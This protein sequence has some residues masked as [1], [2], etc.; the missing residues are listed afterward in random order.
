MA[1]LKGEVEKII[2]SGCILAVQP[3]ISLMRSFDQRAH[4]YKG[5][6]LRIEGVCGDNT[7]EFL[8][9]VGKEAH[10]K[11]Q[12][13]RGMMLSGESCPVLNPRLETAEF[14]KTSRIK[15]INKAGNVISQPPPFHGISPSLE[16]YR[17][18]G[19][20]RLD[21]RTFESKCAT[22][23]WG[24]RMPVE[25]TID[26]WN[27]SKKRYRLETFCYGPKIC[28]SYKAGA[29]RRVPGRNGITWEEEDWVDQEMTLH[30]EPDD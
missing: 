15:V 1:K 18:R 25:I 28:P 12:F 2:W 8:I 29:T 3:R 17:Q 23:I 19:H 4:S 7:G 27:P 24:C 30:R 16:I 26:H 20:R 6:I 9:A 13:L 21:A 14:Y 5:Y 22:C 11:H 10:E